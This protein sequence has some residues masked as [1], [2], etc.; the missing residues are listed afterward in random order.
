M[1]AE[2]REDIRGRDG[3]EEDHGVAANISGSGSFRKV[4]E[5]DDYRLAWRMSCVRKL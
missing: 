2:M 5:G 3:E 4:D 1:R